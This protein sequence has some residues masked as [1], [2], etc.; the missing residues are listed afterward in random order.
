MPRTFSQRSRLY[1]PGSYGPFD[2]DELTKNDTK[3]LVATFTVEDWPNVSPLMTVTV[4]WDTGH[5]T[6]SVIS[7]NPRDRAGNPLPQV[8]VV[9]DVPLSGTGKAEVASGT[10]FV[11]V[12]ETLRTAVTIEAIAA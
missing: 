9:V 11:T 2:V 12:H 10:I 4:G 5:S 8:R 3:Q 1:A 7:G 6:T